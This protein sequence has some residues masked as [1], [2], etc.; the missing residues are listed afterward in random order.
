MEADLRTSPCL[1][2]DL[3]VGSP[4]I[5]GDAQ[6][7]AEPELTKRLFEAMTSAGVK[8][9]IGRYDEPRLL[10]TAPLFTTGDSLTDER[11]TIHLGLDL[12]AEAGTPV[13]APLAGTIHAFA[14]NAAPQDYGP[15]II[16]KHHP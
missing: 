16:L 8:V 2:F 10:Y 15:V 5:S 6:E 3:S 4:L 1:V 9:G 7:N 11:R 13:Y 12:F 14:N